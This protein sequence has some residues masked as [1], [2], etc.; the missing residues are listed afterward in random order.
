M[1]RRDR[2]LKSDWWPPR[3]GDQKC[4]KNSIIGSG[5]CCPLSYPEK[6]DAA[7]SPKKS[8]E[9]IPHCRVSFYSHPSFD[10]LQLQSQ[11][12]WDDHLPSVLGLAK[13]YLLVNLPESWSTFLSP[14]KQVTVS[15]FIT[16]ANFSGATLKT[17]PP[18]KLYRNSRKLGRPTWPQLWWPNDIPTSSQPMLKTCQR[19]T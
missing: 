17:I 1:R 10:I 16:L 7:R 2:S 11:L 3:F 12:K 9:T 8:K 18:L 13:G 19:H 5:N 15:H 4:V 14:L 6:N